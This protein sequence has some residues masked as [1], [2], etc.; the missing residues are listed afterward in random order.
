MADNDLNNSLAFVGYTVDDMGSETSG[1]N[2]VARDP[3]LNRE[4]VRVLVQAGFSRSETE[5]SDWH[6]ALY[7]EPPS[8]PFTERTS[9][10]LRDNT[11]KANEA[12]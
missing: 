10:Y 1:I 4:F 2:R 12:E 5:D 6:S 11:P 9:G 8:G 7:G 3:E